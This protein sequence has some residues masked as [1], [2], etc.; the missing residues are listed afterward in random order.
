MNTAFWEDILSLRA[1]SMPGLSIR[2][3][4]K[5]QRPSTAP[6]R[7]PPS[8]GRGQSNSRPQ[9]AEAPGLISTGYKKTGVESG[10]SRKG[11]LTQQAA[12]SSSLNFKHGVAFGTGTKMSSKMRH[13]SPAVGG[14][15]SASAITTLHGLV[16]V[17]GS[18]KI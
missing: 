17:K 4:Q 16:P 14:S 3:K 12:L 7:R 9:A 11:A 15:A 18:W 1:L 2:E 5:K 6:T 8:P 13:V 10:K